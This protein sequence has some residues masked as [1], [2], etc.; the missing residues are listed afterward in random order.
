MGKTKILGPK[1]R[2]PPTLSPRSIQGKFP[3]TTDGWWY[4][5]TQSDHLRESGVCRT[6][7]RFSVILFRNTQFLIQLNILDLRVTLTTIRVI[8]F[9]QPSPAV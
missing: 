8:S 5:L 4:L 3:R 1:W 6:V 2:A 7:V 9:L